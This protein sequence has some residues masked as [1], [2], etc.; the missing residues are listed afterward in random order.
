LRYV[1]GFSRTWH[2]TDD[3][4]YSVWS[5]HISGTKPILFFPGLGLGA[6]PYA[7]FAKIFGRTVHIVEVPNIGYSTPLSN[8][9]ATLKTLYEVVSKH[10]EDGTDVFAH[11]FGSVMTAMY[12][13]AIHDKPHPQQN[14]VICDGFV[15]P[16]DIITT[17]IYPFV[18]LTDYSVIRKKPRRWYEFFLF[19]YFGIY[20]I[21]FQA[22]AKRFHNVYANTLW[23]CYPNTNINYVFSKHDIL[24]DTE[25]IAENSDCV[26]LPK[27][28]HGYSVFGRFDKQI[29]TQMIEAGK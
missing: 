5:H 21:E 9:Q 3:G 23:R 12:L 26:L 11:S 19:V 17:H 25:F 14:V 16:C 7:K 28:G 6:V 2:K 20:N 22:W 27:G 8:R 24:Y 1:Q 15:N 18:G 10:V 29:Y 13:N 4:Y